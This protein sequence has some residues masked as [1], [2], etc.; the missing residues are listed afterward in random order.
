[1]KQL[2]LKTSY[3]T[4]SRLGCQNNMPSSS[5]Q[6]VASQNSSSNEQQYQQSLLKEQP[7]RRSP[8][9]QPSRNMRTCFLR[10]PP[11][12]YHPLDHKTT[13]L[14]SRTC[15]CLNERRL[16]H[17]IPSNIKLAKSLLKNISRQ[18]KSP[19]QNLPRLHQSFS[20]KR[21]KLGNYAPAKTTSISI[22]TP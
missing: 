9:R 13:L 18:G 1:M 21:R 17:S 3:M 7:R 12:N 19:L 2:T 11:P 5:T 22:A 10:K 8:Y 15:L 16:T 4:P 14:N 20:S 6:V